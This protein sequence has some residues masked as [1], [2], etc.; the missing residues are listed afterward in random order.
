MGLYKARQFVLYEKS[1]LLEA[2]GLSIIQLTALAILSG[3]DY[4]N[5]TPYL[6][7]DTNVKFIKNIYRDKR[8]ES[9]DK[10]KLDC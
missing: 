6:A 5:N 3:N 9:K 10:V 7:I 8:K 4:I 2:L 1:A